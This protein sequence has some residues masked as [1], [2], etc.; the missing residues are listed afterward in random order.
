[1]PLEIFKLETLRALASETCLDL[2]AHFLLAR[3]QV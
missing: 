3:Y 2:N 1:M